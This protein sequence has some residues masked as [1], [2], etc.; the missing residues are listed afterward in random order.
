[1]KFYQGAADAQALV[2]L[3]TPDNLQIFDHVDG[4]F[5]MNFKLNDVSSNSPKLVC[6]N[7]RSTASSG[8]RPKSR[9]T[10]PK[11]WQVPTSARSYK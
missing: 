9:E 3:L 8:S 1:M 2:G 7:L 4:R 5:F 6:S 11:S 10:H